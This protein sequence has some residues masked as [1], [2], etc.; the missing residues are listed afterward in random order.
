M[1][2]KVIFRLHALNDPDRFL[3]AVRELAPPLVVIDYDL[4]A[5]NGLSLV[6]AC[7][8][9]GYGGRIIMLTA[10]AD[11][12]DSLRKAAMAAGCDEFLQKPIDVPA[13]VRISQSF[14]EGTQ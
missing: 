8:Q 9:E 6:A 10:S 4:G 2:W 7:R 5:K 1:C 13:L 14:L 11:V 12:D 3:A